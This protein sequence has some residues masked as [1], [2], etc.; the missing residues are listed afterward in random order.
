MN[1][2][3]LRFCQ[4]DGKSQI[5]RQKENLFEWANYVLHSIWIALKI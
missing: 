1:S 2:F 5:Q 4:I 3:I